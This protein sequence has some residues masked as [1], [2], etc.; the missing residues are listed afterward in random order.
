[1]VEAGVAACVQCLPGVQSTYRWQ[2]KVEQNDE[3]LLLIKTAATQV[4]EA[5]TWLRARHPYELP[6]ILSV[7]S[8]TGLPAYLRWLADATRPD[9]AD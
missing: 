3:V 6:E 8:A 5:M 2:G 9:A 7:E 1:M 4:A